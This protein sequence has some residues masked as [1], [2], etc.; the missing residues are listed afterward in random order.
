LADIVNL[1]TKG[2]YSRF[3]TL[4]ERNIEEID[5]PILRGFLRDITT[6]LTNWFENPEVVCCLIQGIWAWYVKSSMDQDFKINLLSTNFG[7]WIDA[8]VAFLDLIIALLSGQMKKFAFFLP[9]VFKEIMNGVYAAIITLLQQTFITLRDSIFGRVL[10]IIR[11]EALRDR[12]WAKCLPLHDLI[13]VMLKYVDDYGLFADLFNKMT[14]LIAGEYN[15]WKAMKDLCVSSKDLEFLLWLRDLLLKM[16]Y[17]YASLDLCV[18]YAYSPDAQNPDIAQII[19]SGP[20]IRGQGDLPPDIK[21]SDLGY[22]FMPSDRGRILIDKNRLQEN[23][24]IPLLSNSSVREFLHTYMGY[25][26]DQIDNILTNSLASDSIQG[27]NINSDRLS[28]INADCP[29]TPEPEALIRWA[30]GL[31]DRGK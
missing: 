12:V 2:T 31:R 5:K 24:S 8:L 7:K 26:Y 16:K 27:T 3:N 21:P 19:Q 10:D 22:T 30:L 18:Q 29:N 23:G 20:M 14:G 1:S 13:R 17:A 15:F 25:N 9:D 28:N 6:V 4:L 11:Q